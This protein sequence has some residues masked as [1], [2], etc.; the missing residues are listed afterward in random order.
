VS[1][2]LSNNS[3]QRQRI[4]RLQNWLIALAVAVVFLGVAAPTGVVLFFNAQ[5]EETQTTIVCENAKT[6]IAILQAGIRNGD[7][8]EDIAR[9]LGLPIPPPPPIVIPELPE[10]C[11]E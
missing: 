10:E 4:K 6:A 5:S 3:D 2:P 8:T 1:T 11:R 9:S 7:I